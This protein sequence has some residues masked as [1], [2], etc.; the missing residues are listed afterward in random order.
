MWY[1]NFYRL[2][3]ISLQDTVN[4]QRI[5]TMRWCT[6][7]RRSYGRVLSG[8]YY[9]VLQLW[10]SIDQREYPKFWKIW[11][12]IDVVPKSCAAPSLTPVPLC[13][14]VHVCRSLGVRCVSRFTNEFTTRMLIFLPRQCWLFFEFLFKVST[15][16]QRIFFPCWKREL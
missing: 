1:V 3:H 8:T 5:K 2:K 16:H 14:L 4:T 6:H 9:I 12:R 15:L 7:S 11:G 10:A 13:T